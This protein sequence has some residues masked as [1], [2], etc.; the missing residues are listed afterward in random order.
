M[1]LYIAYMVYAIWY[2]NVNAF[3]LLFDTCIVSLWL[4][5]HAERSRKLFIIAGRKIVKANRK[6]NT[7]IPYLRIIITVVVI[8]VLLVFLIYE[9][10]HDTRKLVPFGGL[11]LLLFLTLLTSRSPSKI[12]WTPVIWGILLQFLFGLIILRWPIG[13]GVFEFIASQ[14]SAFLSYTDNATKIVFGEEGL[15]EHPIVFK[16]LPVVVFFN[17]ITNVLY[18]LG[19]MQ[20]IIRVIARVIRFVMKTSSIESFAAAAQIFIGQT[21]SSI[22]LKPFLKDISRSGLNSVMTGGFAT[23]AC[24]YIAA[25]IELG[26]P[27]QHLVAA[28][29]MSAPAALAVAKLGWPEN[30]EVE[31]T[32]LSN[33]QFDVGQETNLLEAASAGA[34]STVKLV[35]YVVV[36]LIAFLAILSFLDAAI[37]FYGER[38]GHPEINFEWLCSYLFMPLA[39][40]SGIPWN[41]CR[42]VATLIGKKI[43]LHDFLAY[44]D[45]GRLIKND[46]IEDRSAVIATYILCGFGS[47]A[48]IGVTLGALTAAEPSRRRDYARGVFRAFVCGNVACFMTACV[49]GM[50]Y[51]EFTPMLYNNATNCNMTSLSSCNTTISNSSLYVLDLRNI[52]QYE[53]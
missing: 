41:D 31:E 43:V 15:K 32:D 16:V 51:T 25:Y 52:T 48:S 36:N 27:A 39:V 9:W 53:F 14:I 24:T 2:D 47:I 17:A 45:L 30:S 40:I 46:Q 20:V 26:V 3:L 35:A 23:I 38:V 10:I 44:M 33:I 49:A 42:T 50:L 12:K 4:A 1:L 6:V 7:K 18:Y 28:S 11:I 5:A 37:S 19:A 8:L 22:A 29:F 21:E 13:Y 34:T